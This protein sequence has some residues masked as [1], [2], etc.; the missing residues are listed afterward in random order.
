MSVGLLL[1]LVAGGFFIVK[2]IASGTNSAGIST[3]SNS[4]D[5]TV[6]RSNPW[7]LPDIDS[8]SQKGTFKKD[9]DASI[10]KASGST[11]VPFALIKAHA[12]RESSLDP[13]AYHY[14]NK[15]SGASYGLLQTEWRSGDDRFAKYGYPDSV[16]GSDGS[17]LYDPD[18]SS[19]IGA[20]I[21]RDNLNWL[22]GN[23]RDAVNAYNTG[24]REAQRPAPGNYV[25]NVLSYYSQILGVS[26]S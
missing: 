11:G 5:S 12:I 15:S 22:S 8:A 26:V 23:L 2:G 17:G 1:A 10:E 4:G 6:T 24:T 14:D 7:G 20:C 9:Y 3:G 21:I 16:L 25:D 13:I 19:F 18:V